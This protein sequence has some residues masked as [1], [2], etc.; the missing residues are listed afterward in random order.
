MLSLK[1]ILLLTLSGIAAA[2]PLANKHPR[3]AGTDLLLADLV[4]LDN[5][6]MELTRQVDAY[7][8]MVSLLIPIK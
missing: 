6:V 7:E 4:N 5:S 8:G 3:D 2:S 1:N